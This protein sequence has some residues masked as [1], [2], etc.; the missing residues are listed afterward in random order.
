VVR[1]IRKREINSSWREDERKTEKFERST[2]KTS[3]G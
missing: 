2:V 1:L 3:N